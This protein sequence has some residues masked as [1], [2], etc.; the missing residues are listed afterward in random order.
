MFPLLRT[1]VEERFAA[2]ERHLKASLAKKELSQMARG[3]AFVEIYGIYEY[4]VKNAVRQAAVEAAKHAHPYADLRPSLLA[5]FLEP[6]FRSVRDSPKHGLWESRLALLQQVRSKKP[7]VIVGAVVVPDDDNHYRHSR[8]QLILK[9]FG[10][11][12]AVTTRKR[13]MYLIDDVV[14]KRNLIAHGEATAAEVGRNLTHGEVHA[15]VRRMRS[16]C[17]RLIKMLEEHCSDSAKLCR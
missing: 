14:E 8:L 7:A 2:I 1:E 10:I 13:Y 15:T 3:F 17:L 6:E 16:V 4:A 5:L 12:R 11:D 9:V